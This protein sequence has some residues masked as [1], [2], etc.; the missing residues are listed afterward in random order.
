VGLLHCPRGSAWWLRHIFFVIGELASLVFFVHLSL[1]IK[2]NSVAY[3]LILDLTTRCSI[4]GQ[5]FIFEEA[6]DEL[7]LIVGAILAI[8]TVL[9]FSLHKLEEGHVGVYYR[10]FISNK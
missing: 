6:M 9:N 3:V 7:P 5:I 2:A 1:S 4:F 8:I 10:V